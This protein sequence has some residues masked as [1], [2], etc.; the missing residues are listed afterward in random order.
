MQR[1][2]YGIPRSNEGNAIAV[3]HRKR[4][5]STYH[6][7]GPVTVL[8]VRVNTSALP[9]SINT[10][11]IIEA[12]DICTYDYVH[13]L[14][15]KHK[16]KDTRSGGETQKKLIFGMHESWRLKGQDGDVKQR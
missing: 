13:M 3:I 5:E 4:D 12:R 15:L 9:P 6:R 10:P 1:V 2:W 7:S 14:Y 16:L 11:T 8:P